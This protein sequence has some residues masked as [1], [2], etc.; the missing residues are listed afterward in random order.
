[1]RIYPKFIETT[2]YNVFVIEGYRN[3]KFLLSGSPWITYY[4]ISIGVFYGLEMSGGSNSNI[5]ELDL[6]PK[7]PDLYR[8]WLRNYN[9]N[10]EK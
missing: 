5:V 6:E 8:S 4:D 7:S 9:R 3:G 2:D 10:L 1:M